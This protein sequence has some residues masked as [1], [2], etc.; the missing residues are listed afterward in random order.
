[1]A[2]PGERQIIYQILEIHDKSDLNN[3]LIEQYLKNSRLW[4]SRE[5]VFD[6]F[7]PEKGEHKT[8]M[9]MAPFEGIGYEGEVDIFHDIMILKVDKDNRVLDGLQYTL[10]WAE[11]PLSCDLYRVTKRGEKLKKGLD[12][13]ALQFK[14]IGPGCGPP[15]GVVDNVYNFTEI[16]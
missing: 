8:I 10:E 5:E 7:R 14:A 6:L 2:Y 9:F 11:P 3:D 16:F 4:G 13:S 1:M 15:S 12:V